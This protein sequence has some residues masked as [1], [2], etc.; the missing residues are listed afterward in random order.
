MRLIAALLTVL[1]LSSCAQL[2]IRLHQSVPESVMQTLPLN[3]FIFGF[4]PDPNSPPVCP[5]SS[6]ERLRFSM[7]GRDVALSILTLGIYIP[8]RVVYS[9]APTAPAS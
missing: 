2:E 6:L 1:I 7:S 4:I 8:H 9:C 5:D 3:S